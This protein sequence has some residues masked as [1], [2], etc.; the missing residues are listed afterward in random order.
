M[1]HFENILN[2]KI[3][4]P[5]YGLFLINATDF[6]ATSLSLILAINLLK[7][8]SD[9]SKKLIINDTIGT[10]GKS[11]KNIDFLKKDLLDFKGQIITYDKYTKHDIF[12]NDLYWENL[13]NKSINCDA[14]IITDLLPM[15]PK[16]N[17]TK[18]QEFYKEKLTELRLFAEN[19]QKFILIIESKK[20]HIESISQ[21]IFKENIYTFYT[22]KNKI[23]LLD[24]N[25]EMFSLSLNFLK[26]EE[27]DIAKKIKKIKKINFDNVSKST[28]RTLP[29]C[30]TGFS[31]LDEKLNGGF[32]LGQVVSL[33]SSDN[34]I[35]TQFSI[36]MA[37]SRCASSAWRS[38][39]LCLL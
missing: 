8:A 9:S 18:K 28:L 22:N 2:Q 1:T 35:L 33:V 14:I 34:D 10:L 13:E 20:E 21:Y 19:R 29:L 5:K 27:V 4:R 37:T 38:P 32:E 26:N 17:N 12:L 16:N 7:N 11:N 23:F 31:S 36:Q 15:I 25:K 30:S 39:S 6:N 3:P 24:R